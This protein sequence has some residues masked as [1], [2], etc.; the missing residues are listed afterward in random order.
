MDKYIKNDNFINDDFLLETEEAKV[1]FHKYAKDMPIIDYHCH[2]DP[3]DIAC[4][5]TYDDITDLW[6]SGDHYKWRLMRQCGIDEDLITGN[7]PKEEKFKAWITALEKSIGNPLYHW[8]HLELKRYFDCDMP[9]CTSNADAIYKKCNDILKSGKLSARKI[10]EMSHVEVIGTT[11]DPTDDLKMHEEILADGTFKT[12]CIPTF[13]PDKILLIGGN[14]FTDYISKLEEV[15]GKKITDI[16]ALKEVL[17]DRMEYFNNHGAR[18]SDQSLG[19]FP[20]TLISDEE[21]EEIFRKALNGESLTD[22]EVDGYR[23]MIM[24]FLAENY[25]RLGWVMQLHFGVVRN[26]NRKMFMKVGKDSGFDRIDSGSDIESL[27]RFLDEL[28]YRDILPKTVL[29][30]LNPIMNR[31]LSVLSGCFFEKGIAGKVQH[32]AAWWFNDNKIGICDHLRSISEQGVLGTFI[33]MLTDSRCFLSYTRHEYFRRIL[34]NFIGNMVANGELYWDEELIGKT[35]SDICY[36]NALHF[37]G[38]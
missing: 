14:D 18:S 34:C 10:I 7:K 29:Y 19:Y 9:I 24:M 21:L 25:S 17:K 32:G 11:D 6:L 5:R 2:I 16:T 8:S 22:I 36:N 35:V 12:K 23:T 15:S 3:S 27:G 37:F 1:L 31:S 4:D 33:G 26:S 20:C 13:R 38:L 28:D 30:S